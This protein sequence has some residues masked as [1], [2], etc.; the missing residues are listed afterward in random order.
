MVN[1]PKT[2][3]QWI[4]DNLKKN[5]SNYVD[6]WGKYGKMWGKGQTTFDK[7][8]KAANERAVDFHKRA[9]E[10]KEA[11]SIATVVE[12]A[13]NG[14]KTKI[15]RTFSIQKEVERVDD[16]LAANTTTETLVVNGQ[17]VTNTR[18]LSI[19]EINQL[20]RTKK[21]LTALIGINEG[22]PAPTKTANTNTKGEDVALPPMAV[23][24]AGDVTN[25][26]L[27][28]KDLGSSDY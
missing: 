9:N 4:F 23:Y 12:A 15:E 25:N 28:T 20:L 14:L 26:T 22:D 1:N 10:A 17:I 6:M 7:D 8:W 11:A 24:F 19:A 2:R 13:K 27:I 16:L 21:E 5:L 18:E 3:Q